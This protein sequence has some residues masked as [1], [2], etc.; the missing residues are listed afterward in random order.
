[1]W[2]VLE[3]NYKNPKTQSDLTLPSYCAAESPPRDPTVQISSCATRANRPTLTRGSPA[4]TCDALAPTSTTRAHL[5]QTTRSEAASWLHLGRP[6]EDPDPTVIICSQAGPPY[7]FLSLASAPSP[8]PAPVGPFL[9]KQERKKSD[10]R[11]RKANRD[12]SFFS[13]KFIV[14]PKNI[15]Y[16]FEPNQCSFS[17]W[18]LASTFGA[19]TPL[20]S[21]EGS[22]PTRAQDVGPP[23]LNLVEND[24][25]ELKQIWESFDR[26]GRQFFFDTYGDIAQL[27]YVQVDETMLQALIQFWNPGYCCFTLNGKDL[28]PT[29]EEYI[30][31]LRIPNIKEGRIYTR[32]EKSCNRFEVLSQLVGRST[33]WGEG[34]FSK[35][36]ES[37]CFPWYNIA[38]ITG[39]YP[40]PYKKA[41]I[42]T[43]AIYGLV[44]F[45]RIL[46]YIG[47]AVFE[48]FNQFQYCISPVPAIL[49]KTFLSL[50]ACR[51]LEGGR[52]RGCAPL[53]Y[54]WIKSHFWKT[55]RRV[56]SCIYSMDFSPLKQF[57][58]KEWDEVDSTKWVE[59]LRN[60]QEQ[61]LVWR[62]P[63]LKCRRF[64]YKCY[65][66][67]WLML[68]GLWGGIGCAPL[69]VSRQFGSQ[70]FVPY[71]VGLRDSEFAFDTDFKKRVTKI[72]KNWKYCYWIKVA[73]GKEGQDVSMEDH[74]RVFP[75]EAD[76]L[77]VELADAQAVIEKMSVKHTRDLFLSKVEVDMFAGEAEQ[78]MKK[79]LKMKIEYDIQ[80]SDFKKLEAV[81]KHIELRKTP[82]QWRQ[83]IQK[84]EDR[85]KDL[86]EREIEKERKRNHD[87][88]ESEKEK[89]K[90]T[91]ERYQ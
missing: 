16:K 88:I 89:G 50:N 47:V 37:H 29:V 35:K 43:V 72:N 90:Q 51:Q 62:I 22:F 13:Q 27:L 39:T 61:D 85:Q 83:E 12:F 4:S 28:M 15:D 20:S 31:L 68:L 87:L 7:G 49:A 19:S 63:W 10:E 64:L 33:Q 8:A 41:H 79:Y 70:Q 3:P 67:D 5:F 71:T 69:L 30:E 11:D 45:P 14:N 84:A 46:G 65:D 25:K 32:P 21:W 58:V 44:L 57:L 81:V 55:P 9:Q 2:P 91:I 18:A 77:R 78:A 82:A 73:G 1:M 24:L 75:S 34:R 80:N 6:S 26:E 42:L 59:A 53:L 52:F 60:L 23:G 76:L 17:A 36:G 40:D 48:V 66:H 74:L 38:E 86:A 54:V 56:L